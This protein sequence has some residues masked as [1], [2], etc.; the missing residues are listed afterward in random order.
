MVGLVALRKRE[1]LTQLVV[2]V[3][4]LLLSD[5]EPLGPGGSEI[6]RLVGHCLGGV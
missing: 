4:S 3:N 2:L 6:V 5:L 1:L